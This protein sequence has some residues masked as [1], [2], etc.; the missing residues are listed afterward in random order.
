MK[1][2]IGQK[3]VVINEIPYSHLIGHNKKPTRFIEIEVIEEKK[4][5]PGEFDGKE[6]HTGYLGKGSDNYMYGYNYPTAN[7]GGGNTAWVRHCSDEEWYKLSKNEKDEMVKDYLWSDITHYQCPA[8]ATFCKNK[9]YI[10]YCE[11]HQQ[12][13]YT[14]EGCFRCKYNLKSPKVHMNMEEHNWPGWFNE[15]I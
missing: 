13:Y 2:K 7:Q 14:D 1:L 6:I 10:Q 12:H 5:V 8:E 11:K 3:V 15:K 4:N 9:D